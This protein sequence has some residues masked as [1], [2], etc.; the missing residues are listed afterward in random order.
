MLGNEIKKYIKE[1]D[2]KQ[3]KV[4]KD[5]GIK[6]QVLSD[7]LNE[8]RKIE[9]M[10][11]FAICQSLKVSVDYFASKVMKLKTGGQDDIAIRDGA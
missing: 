9:A 11:Y 5:A 8:R 10:E 7:I 6:P 3:T 2:L 4:A 1:Q